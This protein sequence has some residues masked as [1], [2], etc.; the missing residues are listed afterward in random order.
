M[1]LRHADLISSLQ[2]RVRRLFRVILQAIHDPREVRL[3]QILLHQL[4]H[5]GPHA[6]HQHEA[7]GIRQQRIPNPERDLQR[8]FPRIQRRQPA[9]RVEVRVDTQCVL[10][11]DSMHSVRPGGWRGR[12]ARTRRRSGAPQGRLA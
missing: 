12:A 9:E 8:E 3:H 2:D 4:H 5:R 11:R 1:Q 7:L 10:S 6:V